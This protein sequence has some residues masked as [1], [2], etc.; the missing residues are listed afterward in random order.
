MLRGPI[1]LA[2]RA[3]VLI[4][5]RSGSGCRRRP[6]PPLAG[7]RRRPSRLRALQRRA[8]DRPTALR[9]GSPRACRRRRPGRLSLARRAVARRSSSCFRTT[10]TQARPGASPEVSVPLQRSL[11]VPR[12]PVLPA[13]GRSRFGVPPRHATA[14]RRCGRFTRRSRR[15]FGT[16]G[17]AEPSP[18]RFSACARRDGRFSPAVTVRAPARP[19]HAPP[20]LHGRCSAT[21]ASRRTAW[22]MPTHVGSPAALMGFD[23]SRLCSRPRVSRRLRRS[24]PPAVFPAPSPD[25]LMDYVS[26]GR[27]AALH[28]RGLKASPD[29]WPP[30]AAPGL[31]PR[32]RCVVHGGTSRSSGELSCHARSAAALGLS[33][34]RS[35]G[36]PPCG[37]VRGRTVRSARSHGHGRSWASRRV[38]GCTADNRLLRL[39]PA[40]IRPSHARA[41]QRHRGPAPSPP[42]VRR[43]EAL[44]V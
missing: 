6:T 33:S 18:L 5:A 37:R 38:P 3:D 39:L 19:G 41:L 1:G 24:D 35:I 34:F 12:C 32:G 42:D 26:S 14:P 30:A 21:R 29:E 10:L 16:R 31:R 9:G 22:P 25:A 40:A 8:R 28:P 23:P 43:R 17:G 13:S 4:G 2:A 11:A 27:P 7:W 15:P 44:P 36:R 20:L